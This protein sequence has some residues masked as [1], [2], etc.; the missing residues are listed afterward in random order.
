MV[1][2]VDELRLDG[3]S[4]L[5]LATFVTTWMEPEARQLISETLD[6]NMI[7]KDEYPET[8]AIE[9]SCIDMLADLWNAPGEA[10]GTS[11]IGSSEACMLGG[12]AMK[13]R[14]RDRQRAAGKPVDRPHIIGDP[15][16]RLGH[17]PGSPSPVSTA[18]RRGLLCGNRSRRRLR[19]R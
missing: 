9:K 11:T 17:R 1:T 10:V 2:E 19:G 16:S 7:D 15:R 6:K 5:T 8:A 14:W 18:R 4:L 3:F 12:M 13:W